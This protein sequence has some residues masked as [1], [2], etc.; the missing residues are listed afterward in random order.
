MWSK[1]AHNILRFRVPLMVLLGLVTVFM[2]YKSQNIKWSYDLANIVPEKDS[3]MVYFRQFRETFGEDGNI[4][5][6]GVKD[7]AIYKLET[8]KKFSD[9]TYKLEAQEG[10]R[11][12]LGL[13]NLQKLEKNNQKR[14]FELKPI[15]D[16]VPETQDE[17][18]S[19]LKGAASLKFYSGQLINSDNGAT[20]I[21]ITIRKEVLNSKNRD[22]LVNDI[23]DAGK[24]FEEESGV[25]VHFAGLP[26]SRSITTSKVKAELNMFLALSLVV[27]GI[28][29]F[30]FFRS[31]KAVFFPLIIIGVVV[32]W[33][34]GTLAL[35]EYKITL[36][37]GL[38]PPIIVVIGIP[39]SVYMLNRYH[40]EFSEH[41]DQ[42]KALSRIIRKI[43]VVTFITNLTTAVGFFV[44]ATTQIN[45]LVE[46]GIVAGIN[47]MAT[48][49]VSIILIPGVFSLYK[50]PTQKHL[51]HLKFKMLDSVIKWLDVIVHKY[52]PAIFIVT[53]V[54]AGVS[55]Y[56]LSQIKA[57]SYMVDDIPENSPLKKDLRFFEN[58]FS[59]IM[60][61]EIIV[62]TGAKKGV[63]NLRNLRKIDELESFV[64][65][66]DY[67]SQPVSVVSFAKAARQAF[68]NQSPS[69]YS[70]PTNRDMA[71]IMRYLSEG[72]T[73]ELSQSFIDSTGRYV[74]VSLKIADI[75]SNRLDS[76]VNGVIAPKIDSIFVD[77]K[78]DVNLTGTTLMFIKGNKFLIENLLTS[79]IMAFFII[80][81][82]MGLLFRNLKMIIISIIPNIIPLL[83]TA[84]IMGYFGIP[85]KPSTALIFSIVF[86]ISVDDSIHFLAKYRQELFANKFNVSK[87]ISK[88]IRETGSSMIYTSII[89]FFGFIIFVLSEFGGTIALG[90]LTSI[91]LFFAMITNVVVLPALILQFD[92]GKRDKTKHPLIE[93]V[94]ELAEGI[95]ED[96]KPKKKKKS[97]KVS[98]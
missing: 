92:S 17:L 43:G 73:E 29:L 46:F 70:L 35:L 28:I 39:N 82:I 7:S 26:Y 94:P 27:T 88:S 5:A 3:D 11:N 16:G 31:F 2:G 9:L 40:H 56:G 91:T 48:F 60:P 24:A 96:G 64:S 4:M 8:F 18:D 19:L 38:I 50:P 47:I 80:A 45:V 15:F 32:I 74:R 98:N 83:V 25:D 97:S 86:G 69:F 34:M 57:V 79:M 75:G 68:Y 95:D 12:V 62:D 58:N 51:K 85:L 41:G 30:L 61:L 59:G 93:S 72:E 49:V 71:F 66:I 20:L 76:L 55:A 77:S 14:A 33:V 6:I 37:T 52:K 42:M 87:A 67:I 13:P 10:I 44:L 21:L 65:S 84:G 81:I 63:Q 54:V 1:L 22:Q 78:M 23:I 53:I 36:L 90:K 89:L